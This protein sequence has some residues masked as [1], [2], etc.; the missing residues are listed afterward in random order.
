MKKQILTIAAT[1]VGLSALAQGTVDFKNTT[2]TLV[3]NSVTLNRV[4]GGTVFRVVLYYLPDQAGAPTTADFDERG[5][6]LGAS[7]GFQGSSTVASGVFQGGVRSTPTTTVG[8]APAWFQVRAW[9]TAF[10]G[11]YAEASRV[12]GALVGTSN[13]FRGAT[14][15]P[16][17]I[18][19]PTAPG[20]AALGLTTFMLYPVPEPSVIGLGILGI[21]ALLMLRRRK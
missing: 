21:G 15:D 5:V 12:T 18:P 14:A 13:P 11:T 1:V 10:G 8:G 17:A 16:A 3:S 9:E 19:P 7:S 20:L 4:S 6:I 2:S